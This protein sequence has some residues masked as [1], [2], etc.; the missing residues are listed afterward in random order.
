MIGRRPI[1]FRTAPLPTVKIVQPILNCPVI[2]IYLLLFSSRLSFILPH[3]S[4]SVSVLVLGPYKSDQDSQCKSLL[5]CDA[6]SP[7]LDGMRPFLLDNIDMHPE[8]ETRRS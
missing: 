7:R 3:S 2:L 6:Q 4:P 1:P 5:G 8:G